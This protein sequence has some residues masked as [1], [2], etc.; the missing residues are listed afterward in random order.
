L[1]AFETERYYGGGTTAK[2][3]RWQ[4]T[5]TTYKVFN[6]IRIPSQSSVTWKLKEGDFE[7]LKLEVNEVRGMN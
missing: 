6:G 4:I 1:A 3:E 2:K 5:N 7:W